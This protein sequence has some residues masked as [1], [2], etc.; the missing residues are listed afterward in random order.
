MCCAQRTPIELFLWPSFLQQE[1]LRWKVPSLPWR[2]RELHRYTEDLDHKSG[3]IVQNTCDEVKIVLTKESIVY[4][5]SENDFDALSLLSKSNKT[6]R[7]V[8]FVFNLHTLERGD[9]SVAYAV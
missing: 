3:D 1:A 2:T 9:T 6:E 4:C 7:H 5:K 8:R